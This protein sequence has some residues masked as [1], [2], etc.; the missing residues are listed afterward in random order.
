M[1]GIVGIASI[2]N[3]VPNLLQSLQ[4]M[5]Q[6][7]H[8]SCGLVV[9][10]RQG[11]TA[12]APRM[13]RHR[14]AQPISAWMASLAVS[15]PDPNHE[16]STMAKFDGQVGMGHT[17]LAGT[18]GSQVMQSVMP[19]ISHGFDAN[20][21]S[22]AKVA[23]VAVGQLEVTSTLRERLI[24]RGYSFKSTSDSELLAHLIDAIHQSRPEQAIERA[25]QLTGG[26]IAMGVMFHDQPG[27][28]FAVQRSSHIYWCSDSER[29]AWASNSSALPCGPHDIM[30]LQE[31]LVLEF[32]PG[33]PHI[34]H[35]L[36]P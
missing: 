32:Q 14:R 36:D 10:G 15:T 3:T 6:A 1:S 25:L 12:V 29:H 22:P 24:E 2:H 5:E 21:N 26:P 7:N 9:Y 8:N 23:V 33:H 13:H 11:K 31:G 20:L 17:G 30:V 35:R 18:Q 19:H 28:L 4:R 27:H 34:G 16:S